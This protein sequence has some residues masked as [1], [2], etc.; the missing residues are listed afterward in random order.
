MYMEMKTMMHS[1]PHS[2]SVYHEGHVAIPSRAPSTRRESTPATRFDDKLNEITDKARNLLDGIT[3]CSLI[4]FHKLGKLVIEAVQLNPISTRREARD[5]LAESLNVKP[6]SLDVCAKLARAYTA[7]ELRELTKPPLSLTHIRVLINHNQLGSLG[8]WADRIAVKNMSVAGLEAELRGQRASQR[9]GSG[10]RPAP[11]KSLSSGVGMLVKSATTFGNKLE[12]AMFGDEFDVAGEVR[13][14]P[15][16]ELTEEL[17]AQ[18]V[19]AIEKLEATGA[20][21]TGHARRMR[22]EALPWIERVIER[23]RIEEAKAAHN[24][25]GSVVPAHG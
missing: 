24:S 20:Q 22:E 1:K 7:T 8:R 25:G 13:N 14:T 11:P 2:R 10:R 23:R 19:A 9:E 18:F 17:R 12:F 6:R 3:R 16:D 21:A 4:N 15:P 5:L